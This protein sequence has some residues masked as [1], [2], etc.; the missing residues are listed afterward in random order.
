MM[1]NLIL[2]FY[3]AALSYSEWH[4]L[5]KQYAIEPKF[6]ACAQINFPLKCLEQEIFQKLSLWCSDRLEKNNS[7]RENSQEA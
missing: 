5:A 6:F 7:I 1:A 2:C 4:A 3:H